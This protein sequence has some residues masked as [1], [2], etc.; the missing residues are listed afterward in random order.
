MSKAHN[1][2]IRG[3]DPTGHAEILALRKAAKSFG[4]Y[5]LL[6]TKIYVTIEPCI[7]CTAALIHARVGEIIFG[8]PD[9]KWGGLQSLYRLGDDKRLN[10]QIRVTSGVL[11]SECRGIIQAFFAQRRKNPQAPF[12][13]VSPLKPEET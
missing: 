4:N 6:Q 9:P 7:M 11:E 10:H 3:H 5:R 13:Q 8:V 1:E 12:L 2:T